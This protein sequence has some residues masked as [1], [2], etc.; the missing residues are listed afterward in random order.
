MKQFDSAPKDMS[1]DEY[2]EE[3]FDFALLEQ[4]P[5]LIFNTYI[6]DRTM[7]YYNA[8]GNFT[9]ME[10]PTFNKPN[11]LVYLM[12]YTQILDPPETMNKL[13]FHLTEV[14]EWTGFWYATAAS[15]TLCQCTNMRVAPYTNITNEN[16]GMPIA[17]FYRDQLLRD[18][19][20]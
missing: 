13:Q 20:V 19:I 10:C 18:M 12:M 4:M 2:L 3:Y 9:C 1:V 11:W 8:Y 16:L 15:L 7:L 17:L 6:G 5:R 14:Q